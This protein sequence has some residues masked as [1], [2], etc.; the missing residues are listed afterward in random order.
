MLAIEERGQKEYNS[1]RIY[2]KSNK[3]LA[4]LTNYLV[5]KKNQ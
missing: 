3:N 1:T 4:E 2:S 5:D